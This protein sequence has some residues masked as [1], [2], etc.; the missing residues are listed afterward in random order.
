[1]EYNELYKKLLHQELGKHILELVEKNPPDYEAMI[2][3]KSTIV[4]EEI[5]KLFLNEENIECDDFL[6][7]DEIITI[8]NNHGINTGICHDF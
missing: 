3:Q 8:L 6:L 2:F 7:V 4:L 5:Q 1:M